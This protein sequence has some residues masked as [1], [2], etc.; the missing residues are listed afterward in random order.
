LAYNYTAKLLVKNILEVR[1]PT[2][3]AYGE[4][5]SGNT[6]TMAGCET[7]DIMKAEDVIN[8]PLS[9]KY[10]KLDLEVSAS[11]FEIYNSDVLDLLANKAKLHVIED[12]KLKVEVVGLT[13]KAFKS[14]KGPL[15]LIEQV[16]RARASRRIWANYSSSRAHAIF[17]IIILK[18]DREG[19]MANS[20]I[21]I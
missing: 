16:S 3:F 5:G 15:Q 7:N 17:Q 8:F 19:I 12:R 13:V 9:R 18:I 6:Q 4:T 20:Q 11:F 2:C 10:K 1:I 14:F 21:S